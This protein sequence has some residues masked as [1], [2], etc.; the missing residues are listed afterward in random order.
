MS[1]M[2]VFTPKCWSP[3]SCFSDSTKHALAGTLIHWQ[4]T[5]YWIFTQTKLSSIYRHKPI[6]TYWALMKRHALLTTW[7][8]LRLAILK[9]KLFFTFR[10]RRPWRNPRKRVV[11]GGKPWSPETLLYPN[12]SN[13]FFSFLC[14]E[15][16]VSLLHMQ[17][18]E[19]SNVKFL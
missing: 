8:K 1:S 4:Q 14:Y 12:I 13:Q 17:N 6:F 5:V 2:Y 18:L 10:S 11:R 3:K 19:W 9:L 7:A 15:K 16:A